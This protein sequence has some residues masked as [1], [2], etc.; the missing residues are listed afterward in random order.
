MF[1]AGYS[2][3]EIAKVTMEMKE[4]RT[5]RA[6]SL[7]SQG[8]INHAIMSL[9]SGAA[10]TTG[11]TVR[12]V[13]IIPNAIAGGIVKGSQEMMGLTN[14]VVGS[15]A[16]AAK[17]SSQMVVSGVNT[18]GRVMT[19]AVT[20]VVTGTGKVVTGTGK[21][22]TGTGTLLVK[23]TGKI[24]TETGN[25]TKAAVKGTTDVVKG[26]G[27]LFVG[28]SKAGLS[29]LTES[30]RKI[31]ESSRKLSRIVS[32]GLDSSSSHHTSSSRRRGGGGMDDSSSH[33]QP[34][35][36]RGLGFPSKKKKDRLSLPLK[37]ASESSSS[38][39]PR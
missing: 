8:M 21:V 37:D 10:E 27:L 35:C 30:S 29:M 7:K 6:E 17:R 28:T 20:D 5:L 16:L 33:L 4:Y 2:I 36:T 13:Q 26:T 22:V 25:V 39:S 15:T 3:D 12:T 34:T 18:T 31:T 14:R 19:G 32:N 23:G 11:R 38:E 24:I 9:L 1:A